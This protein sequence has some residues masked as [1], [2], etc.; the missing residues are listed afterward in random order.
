MSPYIK[1][2]LS[3]FDLRSEEK[4]AGFC[5][6]AGSCPDLILDPNTQDPMFTPEEC[7]TRMAYQSVMIHVAV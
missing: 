7:A 6:L 1:P 2:E 5:S 4:F 3:F